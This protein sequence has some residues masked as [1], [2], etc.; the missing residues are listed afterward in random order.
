[1]P[2]V[3]MTFLERQTD[4]SYYIYFLKGIRTQK[5]FEKIEDFDKSKAQG[6][7]KNKVNRTSSSFETSVYSSLSD[8][9]LVNS[10]L[11]CNNIAAARPRSCSIW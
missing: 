7:P 9:N 3:E 11:R 4:L 10:K 2:L 1:M 5:Q 8:S 6:K